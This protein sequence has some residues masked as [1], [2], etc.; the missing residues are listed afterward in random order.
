MRHVEAERI[1]VAMTLSMERTRPS[2]LARQRW[3][4]FS[5]LEGLYSQMDQLMQSVVGAPATLVP[6]DIEE[7]DDGYLV[8][9]DLPGVER[10]Q[11]DVEVRHNTLRITGEI[12]ER[13]RKGRLR[14]QSRPVGHFDYVVAIPGEID[15]EQVEAMHS[16]GV[17][18]VKL[19]KPA[20]S[21]PRRIEVKGA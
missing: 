5:E 8:E 15:Q 7:L 3:E 4:P 10:E 14:R 9:I 17:L 13:E 16:N 21:R 19:G 18:T 12:K 2:S 6:A 1:D 11:I 20:Q